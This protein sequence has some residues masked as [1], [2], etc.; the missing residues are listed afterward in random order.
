M[1]SP[2]FYWG[3]VVRAGWLLK[4]H[5]HK[6][7]IQDSNNS[8]FFRGMERTETSDQPPVTDTIE[9]IRNTSGD[10]QVVEEA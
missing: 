7:K 2:L 9:S 4:L 1:L 6:R 10:N 3:D 8:Q 5:L